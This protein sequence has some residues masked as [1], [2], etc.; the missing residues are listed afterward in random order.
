MTA[1]TMVPG[2]PPFQKIEKLFSIYFHHEAF[3][4]AS[5]YYCGFQ[6]KQGSAICQLLQLRC[7][8]RVSPK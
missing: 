2:V 8:S 7:F 6:I 3:A 4:K 1:V 5:D